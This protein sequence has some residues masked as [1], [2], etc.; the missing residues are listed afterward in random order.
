MTT[1]HLSSAELV[2]HLLNRIGEIDASGPQLNAVLA[3]NPDAMAT[4]VRRDAEQR[5]GHERGPLHGV[6]VLVK[7]NIDTVDQDTTAGSLALVGHRPTADAPVVTRLRE[8]GAVVLGKANLSEWANLRSPHST[9]GWSAV[10]GL[11]RNPWDLARSAGGSSSGSGAA[12]AAG[13]APLAIGTET[14][15]SIVCPA[16]LNGVVGL[17]PTVG[18]LPAHGI[19]PISHSQDTP[20][21]MA[22]SVQEVAVLLDVLA[23]ADG[24]YSAA[25][26]AESAGDALAGLRVGV[27]R[28][29]FGDH[30]ATDD[31]AENALEVVAR[32]GTTLVDPADVPALPS[33]DAGADELT[34]LLHELKHDLAAY[35]ATRPEGAPRSLDDV[36]V[37][38][39]AHA[40]T[41]LAWFGQEFFEQALATG[42][43]DDEGYLT[44]RAR[45]LRATRDDGLDAVIGEHRLDAIVAPAYGPAW[46]SDLVNGDH[47]TGG[48]VTAAPAVAGYPVLSVP[49]GLV[50]GLPVGLALV[51]T[52]GSE[53]SLLRLARGIELALGLTQDGAFLPPL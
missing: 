28:A 9:S 45:G 33:Y 38:N 49:I 17:K 41:E 52:A 50:H 26:S 10:G 2:D 20:G 22:R 5:D 27:S 16:S 15:G 36:V 21:P 18:L 46:F 31:V 7:D 3:V 8:A 23:G 29:M 4:A 39:R 42:G 30:P 6:P 44:A 1:P 43:L 53:P 14:D 51:G 24:R 37:F 35:L 48:R 32:H 40:E 19:V 11:T 34:V 12:V 25:A 13:L 47:M